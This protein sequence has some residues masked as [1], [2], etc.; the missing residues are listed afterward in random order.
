LYFLI[1]YF[2]SIQNLSSLFLKESVIPAEMTDSG[3]LFQ[4][5][6]IRVQKIFH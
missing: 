2:G 6:I 3:K 4:A 1:F 5:F